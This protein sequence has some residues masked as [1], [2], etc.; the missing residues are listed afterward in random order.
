MYRVLS[1]SRNVHL[2]LS[3]NNIL[4][5]AGFSVISPKEPEQAP[6]LATQQLVDAVVIGHSINESLR[7]ELITELRRACPLCLVC[8]VYEAPATAGEP[9]ADASLD[10]TSGPEPLIRFL[11]DRLPKKEAKAS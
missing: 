7:K 3:R 4:A 1:I 8:F 9:L 11:R 5:L 10:V 6:L 2:L